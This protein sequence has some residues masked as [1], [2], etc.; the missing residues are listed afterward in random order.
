MKTKWRT[1]AAW[2]GAASAAALFGVSVTVLAQGQQPKTVEFKTGKFQ[3]NVGSIT[4]S[5]TLD[6][7]AGSQL[8]F[9]QGKARYGAV[10][11][12]GR[13]CQVRFSLTDVKGPGKYG[14]ENIFNLSLTWGRSMDAWNFNR[15]QDD[16]TFTFTELDDGGAKG[17][18]ACT[19]TGPVAKATLSAAP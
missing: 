8:V 4:C 6:S 9:Y 14:K 3:V 13:N 12:D 5:A 19:G 18:V 15:S 10:Y 2:K 11:T 17:S 1:L 7:A 16:C